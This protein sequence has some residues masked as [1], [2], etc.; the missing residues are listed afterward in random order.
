MK[1]TY[2]LSAAWYFAF[3]AA[4]DL[5]DF[6]DC[7]VSTRQPA[8]LEPFQSSQHLSLSSCIYS[9]SSTNII[10]VTC[11]IAAHTYSG[12]YSTCAITDGACVCNYPNFIS[13]YQTVCV[14]AGGFCT[15]AT[16]S[17]GTFNFYRRLMMFQDVKS[18][19]CE[20]M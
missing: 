9:Y 15:D 16:E 17:Q 14:P 6:P 10:K 12:A 2:L 3:V 1:F 7:G 8:S 4:I 5:E 11:F 13:Q 18:D 20:M 19:L